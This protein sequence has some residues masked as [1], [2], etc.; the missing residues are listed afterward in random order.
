MIEG[1]ITLRSNNCKFA[2]LS[3]L[4]LFL[5]TGCNIDIPDL[6]SNASDFV[7][8]AADSVLDYTE[9]NS[10][11]T[12]H[13]YAVNTFNE[14]FELV[15]EK[16]TQAIF[17]MFSDYVRENVDIMPEIEKLVEFMDGEIAEMGHVGAS[18][19]YSSTRDGVAVSAA[20]TAS[21]D[22]IT[23]NGITY[24][25]KVG[26]ITADADETKLGL[27]WIYILNCEAESAYSKEWGEWNER[28]IN[29]AKEDEPQRPEN[30]S[31][32]VNY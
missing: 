25:F 13:K 32:R 2:F 24:W 18:S 23:A 11:I 17:D 10:S 5:L 30:Y 1:S 27:N 29:G 20:Y 7:S 21:A 26:V 14:V 9:E 8:E 3:L 4:I 6:I 28:R 15:Q 12:P 31:V 22:I 16:D 19:Q